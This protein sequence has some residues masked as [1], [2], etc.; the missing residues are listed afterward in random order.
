MR[1]VAEGLVKK[2]WKD[3]EGVELTGQ[4]PV[5]T[6]Q[7]AMG[8]VCVSLLRYLCDDQPFRRA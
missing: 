7:E 2:V 5:M 4:F 8:K 6:Y 1:D 3:F